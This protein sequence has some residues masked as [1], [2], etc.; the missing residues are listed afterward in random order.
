[1]LFVHAAPG[2]PLDGDGGGSRHL[3]EVIRAM[4]RAGHRVTLVARRATRAAGDP[5]PAL[6]CE[7]RPW[8]Q[9]TLPGFLQ[10]MPS[11]DETVYDL[12]LGRYLQRLA[13]G[14]RPTVVYERFSLF[15]LAGLRT[16]RALGI[17]GV[18]EVNAPLAAERQAHEGLRAGGLAARREQ[19]ILTS[20]DRLVVVSRW[21]E[22]HARGLGVAPERITVQPNGVD[23]HA[24]R[25][26]SRPSPPPELAQLAGR[27]TV[28]FCGSLK[29]WHDLEV[30]LQAL[31]ATPEVADAAL[32]VVGDGPGGPAARARADELDLGE[33][34]VWAGA[35]SAEQVP[36]LLA[37]CHTICVPS[38]P[39]D[40][41]YFSP[42][43]LLEGLAMGIPVVA[44]DV[45][46]A[47]RVAGGQPPAAR[48]VPPADPGA[49]GRALAEIRGDPELA[50]RLAAEGRRRAERHTW[51]RV[52]EASLAG[53]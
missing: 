35:R 48:L 44:T 38:P 49:L 24:F 3:R 13:A 11:V 1:V 42:L 20:A 22:R 51:D 53:L 9:G 12:R 7:L 5:L 14:I 15:S 36:D 37:L 45:G 50:A 40:D 39:S 18:L 2:I 28:G 31:A 21:L 33:R 27:F 30:L 4:D 8:P 26:R 46:D 32:L 17:P 41:F 52:V 34:V 6:P 16:A 29:P 25:P 23:P 19:E 43:K 10:R 47:A